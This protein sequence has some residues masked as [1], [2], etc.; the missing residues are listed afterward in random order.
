MLSKNETSSICRSFSTCTVVLLPRKTGKPY[1]GLLHHTALRPNR[2]VGQVRLPRLL[3]ATEKQEKSQHLRWRRLS[4]GWSITLLAAWRSPDF[5]HLFTVRDLS[6]PHHNKHQMKSKLIHFYRTSRPTPNLGSLVEERDQI[7]VVLSL[8]R[9][10]L[11]IVRI[12]LRLSGLV[13]FLALCRI[14]I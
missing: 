12:L 8:F 9:Q 1:D 5:T 4:S 2:G 10:F 7:L 6:V 3:K 11:L 14:C 13:P